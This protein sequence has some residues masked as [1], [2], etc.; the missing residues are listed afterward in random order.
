MAASYGTAKTLL[1]PRSTPT[2]R[3][4][5]FS[6]IG[7]KTPTRAGVYEAGGGT[8][9]PPRAQAMG[10]RGTH[11]TAA[12]PV[13]GTRVRAPKSTAGKT[14]G[15]ALF[16]AARAPSGIAAPSGRG[17]TPS[18]GK[19]FTSTQ[20]DVAGAGAPTQKKTSTAINDYG[21]VFY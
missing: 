18:M 4:A 15:T 14:M 2:S 16:R 13:G 11:M 7:A 21:G 6:P 8:G 10:T 3:K 9:H 20:V 5:A 1:K 19:A 17:A 12:K